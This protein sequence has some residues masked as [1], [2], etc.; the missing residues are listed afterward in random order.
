[1]LK[2]KI[3]IRDIG[4]VVL[5]N[6]VKIFKRFGPLFLIFKLFFLKNTNNLGKNQTLDKII[7]F[8]III[9]NLSTLAAAGFL[10]IN[11]HT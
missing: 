6:M 8:A 7:I 1:M 11:H 5:R 4:N 10:K 9:I 2:M 3:W